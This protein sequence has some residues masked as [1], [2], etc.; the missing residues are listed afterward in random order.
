M[1]F[2]I[3]L[4]VVYL[5]FLFTYSWGLLRKLNTHTNSFL[6]VDK[7]WLRN[8]YT[9]E[10]AVQQTF[11]LFINSNLRFCLILQCSG[12]KV[13]R[14]Q[15]GRKKIIRETAP[16][17]SQMIAYFFA[18]GP[19]SGLTFSVIPLEVLWKWAPIWGKK[20]CQDILLSTWTCCLY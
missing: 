8:F 4:K 16:C 11:N 20:V 19:N 13:V 15:Q 9:R 14:Y 12:S 10:C 7:M 3:Y 17:Q 6:R 2:I 5:Q 1:F 18:F